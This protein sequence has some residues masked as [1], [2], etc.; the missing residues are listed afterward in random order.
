MYAD[1]QWTD[2]SLE[3]QSEDKYA[4]EENG[5]PNSASVEEDSYNELYAKI[6]NDVRKEIEMLKGDRDRKGKDMD[7]AK[8]LRLISEYKEFKRNN[9]QHYRFK[10]ASSA[11]MF[12]KVSIFTSI[13]NLTNLTPKGRNSNQLFTWCRYTLTRLPL[14]TLKETRRSRQRLS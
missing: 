8:L 5:T 7:R 9:I 10:S 3:G 14:T 6:L 2:D 1:V 11:A 4:N 12:G 13:S